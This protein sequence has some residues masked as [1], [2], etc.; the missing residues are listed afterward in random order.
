MEPENGNA[1]CQKCGEY[2]SARHDRPECPHRFTL[3]ERVEKKTRIRGK[4][5]GENDVS[6]LLRTSEEI[7]ESVRTVAL[8]DGVS[9]NA[10]IVEAIGIRLGFK[11][12]EVTKVI[13]YKWVPQL[14]S[15]V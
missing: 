10:W 13:G 7:R 4:L 1:L 6:T 3:P 8:E 5:Q 9:M 12:I 14:K 11:K 2:Y 15:I